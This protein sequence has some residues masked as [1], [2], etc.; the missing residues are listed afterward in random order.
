MVVTFS[1]STANIK[2]TM[3]NDRNAVIGGYARDYP[4]KGDPS[5]I[6]NPDGSRITF[7][8]TAR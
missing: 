3:K 5:K 8:L 7:S 6:K 1:A 4:I 2:G